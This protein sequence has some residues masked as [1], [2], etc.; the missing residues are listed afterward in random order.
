MS[1]KEQ[2]EVTTTDKAKVVL[3]IGVFLAGVV[4]FYLFEDQSP[5]I[6]VIGMVVVAIAAIGIAMTSQQGRNAWAFAREARQELR[7]VV[8][9]TRQESVQTTLIVLVMVVIVSI[10]LWLMDIFFN[11]GVG[12]LV[13]PGG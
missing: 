4:G 9:P 10:L 5:L 13:R 1:A 12:A 11:W 3:A 6:R 8:W 7:K 2:T